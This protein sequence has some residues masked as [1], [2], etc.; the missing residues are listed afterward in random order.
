MKPR[1]LSELTTRITRS[2]LGSTSPASV[3]ARSRA[4]F[5]TSW[6]TSLEQSLH[7]LIPPESL[8][9][10]LVRS[11]IAHPSMAPHPSL[12]L[13]FFTWCAQQPN[14]S[15]DAAAYDTVIRYLSASR[16][17]PSAVRRLLREVKA[18]GL[19]LQGKTYEGVLG[20]F[21]R[22][23]MIDD[24]FWV[25]CEMLRWDCDLGMS[26]CNGLLGDL[27]SDGR[28]KSARKVFDQMILRGVG[29]TTLGIGL[30]LWR[31]CRLVDVEGILMMI[32]K[33]LGCS[34]GNTIDGSVVVVLIVHG[35]CKESR[36]EDANAV[37]DDLRNR[38]WKPDFIAYRVVAEEFGRLND[39]VGRE[40]VL[41]RKRKLGVAPR[42]NEYTGFLF[43]LISE[44]R[45][46]E[47]KELCEVIVSGDFQLQEDV[48]NSLV[49]TVSADY[50]E[51][52]VDF[53]KYMIQK[54]KLPTLLT[55]T[56][57]GK[58]LAKHRSGDEL[59][60]VYDLL[61]SENYFNDAESYNVIISCL[62]D[63]GRVKEAYGILQEMR[64]RRLGMG[65]STYN[66]IFDACC[67]DDLIRPAKKL[68]DE[69]FSYGCEANL[70]TYEILISKFSEIAEVEEAERLFS[71]MLAKGLLPSHT[72]Y[73]SLIL[74]LCDEGKAE[75]ALRIF[76]AAIKMDVS[77]AQD[78]LGVFVQCLC[79]NGIL[80]AASRAMTCFPNEM[81]N[82]E[83][84]MTLLT[85]L[86]DA[87][88]MTI[89]V[90]H[91]KWLRENSPNALGAVSAAVEAIVS[92]TTSR[93]EQLSKLLHMLKAGSY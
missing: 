58:N 11:V 46:R 63:C 3:A 6:T 80:D 82:P 26:A 42:M 61:I 70:R 2:L 79:R 84:H 81:V 64:K 17:N 48:L 20:F 59:L 53:L 52:G 49:G 22:N 73:R 14:Y 33:V 51:H 15:H 71:H 72:I 34:A 21:L 4:P 78:V 76:D 55:L 50:P 39:M 60:G 65:I 43:G 77:L 30:F 83:A 37:L 87:N 27:A 91:V 56:N 90:K 9:S 28:V 69:M 85:C 38:G 40:S 67:K 36:L 23:G 44:R 32:D 24:G 54:G 75:A 45:I 18:R 88:E 47:A 29:F 92:S 74:G 57:L 35:L 93:Q 86:A 89:A 10:D 7:G 19:A 31:F 5:L 25:F 13:S 68:W 41:K 62:C 8:T 16:N 66:L 12:S 1:T